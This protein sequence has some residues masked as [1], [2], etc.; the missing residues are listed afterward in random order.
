MS[1]PYSYFCHSRPLSIPPQSPPWLQ[2]QPLVS[3]L[4]VDITTSRTKG[5][6]AVKNGGSS[7]EK[8]FDELV[9]RSPS[10][11]LSPPGS[12]ANQALSLPQE[13]HEQKS[14]VRRA[15]DA[16]EADD[17]AKLPQSPPTP[18]PWQDKP[19]EAAWRTRLPPRLPI[20]KWDM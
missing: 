14:G 15:R 5:N 7:L 12:P 2:H 9:P 6:K 3:P 18:T 17:A 16:L 19:K 8:L 10:I 11:R 1:L 20:P 13:T 4:P